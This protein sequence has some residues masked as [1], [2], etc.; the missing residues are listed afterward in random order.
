MTQTTVTLNNDVEMPLEGLGVFR[1]EDQAV[2]AQSV[3]AAIRAGY[4]LIDTA[5]IYQNEQGVGE[6]IKAACK[7]TGLKREDLFITSKVWNADQGYAS[8]LKAYQ[9][10]LDRL[11]LDYLDLYLIHWP[12]EGRY[13]ETWR[14]MEH[15]YKEGKVRA[16]GVSNFQIHHLED[17]LDGAEVVP[18]VNQV[19]RH[20]RLTQ[21]PLKDFSEAHGIRLEAWAPLMV[22]ELLQDK[23][24]GAIAEKYGKSAAQ[25]IL[26]WHIQGG[27]I[28]IP[29]SVNEDRIKEN[30]AIFDFELTEA[31]MAAINALNQDHRTGADP[32]NFDF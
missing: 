28:A 31:D 25:V 9:D 32:D 11:G 30:F 6:G 14:A 26:R 2:A 8:T 24:I 4:R 12:V 1:V 5:A 22:G 23:T 17:L 7:E 15:L 29:K 27:V 19:E 21:Q 10:S 20:P 18:V 13:K 16:I 3:Q